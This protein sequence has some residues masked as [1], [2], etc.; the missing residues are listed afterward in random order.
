MK[1]MNLLSAIVC[2][3]MAFVIWQGSSCHSSNSRM[4]NNSGANSSGST[5][6]SGL[7]GLWGGQHIN[8]EVSDTGAEIEYDC[9][10][11][12]ITETI[13]PDR[14]GNF[15][16][17]GVHIAEHP[18]PVRQ[19]EQNEQPATYRGSISGDT[20][21]LTVRLAKNNETIG[22]FT[23]THGKTGRVFKCK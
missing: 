21:T 17:K 12:Q 14:N 9:A 2:L 20:M 1:R 22:T 3:P 6:T 18:G 15:E 7:H 8:M 10:H 19:G 4:S 13:V 23:L 5:Q 11:G 16:A